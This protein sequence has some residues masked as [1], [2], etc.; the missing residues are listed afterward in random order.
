ML[1]QANDVCMLLRKVSARQNDSFGL[2][3]RREIEV[4][5]Q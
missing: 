3:F 1:S 4:N 2:A 5:R